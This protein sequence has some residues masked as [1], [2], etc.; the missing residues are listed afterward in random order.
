MEKAVVSKEKV[1]KMKTE[2]KL[3]KIMYGAV[4]LYIVVMFGIFPLYYQDKYFNMGEAKYEFAKGISVIYFSI[5]ILCQILKSGIKTGNRLRKKQRIISFAN[6]SGTD[7]FVIA[8]AVSVGISFCVTSYKQEAIWGYPEWNMG[9]ISQLLFVLIYFFVSRYAKWDN[10]LLIPILGSSA[11]IYVLA[12]LQRFQIDPL[13]MYDEIAGTDYASFLS[14]I[15]NINWYSGY[16]CIILPIGMF[17]FWYAK[18]TT[19]R[20]ALSAYLLIGFASLVTQN[21]DSAYVALGV[22]LWVLFYC[23]LNSNEHM[24][25]FLGI[26]IIGLLSFKIVGCLQMAYPNRVVD[27]DP[28]SA[29]LSQSNVTMVVLLLVGVL[30]AILDK[31]DANKTFDLAKCKRLHVIVIG[32]T[33]MGIIGM[34]I[35]VCLTTADKLPDALI[36]L[37]EINY[38]NFNEEWGNGRGFIWSICTQIYREFPWQYKLFGCGPDCFASYAYG[39]YGEAL[40]AKWGSVALV[41]AHNEWLNSLLCFGLMGAISYPGIFVSQIRTSVKIRKRQPMAIAVMMCV[42]AYIGH[43]LFCYQQIVCTPL[44]FMI[45]GMGEALRREDKKIEKGTVH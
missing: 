6:I 43:D 13:G 2:N 31:K 18:K 36:F 42:A 16:L 8:Y 34:I 10:F 19:T 20:M 3:D 30:Y 41:N 27:I 33:I 29:F 26:L 40:T 25:R 14:T 21:S 1:S 45:I 38:F 4:M 23:S 44:I 17:A 37:K 24:K 15:G 7:W 22:M 35:L 12:I 28:L 9:V 5:L 39:H 11:I 32:V